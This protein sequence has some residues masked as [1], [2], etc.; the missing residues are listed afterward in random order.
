MS[1]L[2]EYLKLIPK[3][4]QNPENLI[5]GIWNET[6][7]LYGTLDEEEAAEIVKRRLICQSCPFHSL[8]AT[9]SKEYFDIFKDHYKTERTESHCSVCGCVETLKTASLNSDCGLDTDARTK[10][11]PLKWTKFNKTK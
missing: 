10:H 9:T 4:L 7:S 3:G 6:K 11:L 2:T 8:H 5:E 1:K